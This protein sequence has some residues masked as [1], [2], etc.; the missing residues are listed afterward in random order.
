M[1]DD[2]SAGK[3][4]VGAVVPVPGATVDA[5]EL[6]DMLAER[7]PSYMVPVLWALLERMP[8]TA[9]GKVDRKA[10]IAAAAPA[11]TGRPQSA[12]PG[13]T[14]TD[15]TERVAALFA[16]AIKQ[17]GNQS[18]EIPAIDRDTDFFRIGGTSLA[19]VQ[20]IRLIKQDLG[21]T[22]KLREFLLNPTPTGVHGLAGKAAT[23]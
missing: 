8:V 17:A 19:A 13:A 15:P 6:R 2:D 21:V 9:N 1:T 14:A 7:L 5:A 22:L 3:R 10:I 12:T 16:Q 11:R 20:L 23:K 4:I 18:R